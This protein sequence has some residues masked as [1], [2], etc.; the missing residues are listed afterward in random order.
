MWRCWYS[1]ACYLSSKPAFP[2]PYWP[3][4]YPPT[5]VIYTNTITRKRRISP[6]N[7]QQIYSQ[8]TTIAWIPKPSRKE[9]LSEQI[10]A[11]LLASSWPRLTRSTDFGKA[12]EK[13]HRGRTSQ[14][15]TKMHVGCMSCRI[16]GQVAATCC[17]S[18]SNGASKHAFQCP[19][20]KHIQQ[21][22]LMHPG[23][24]SWLLSD[25]A[26]SAW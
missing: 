20:R 17:T 6:S 15:G 26:L 3:S 7:H 8:T 21:A 9:A 4:Q 10:N 19:T 25:E 18:D 1:R 11:S 5:P 22:Q 14:R 23:T 24:P 12:L 13:L 2:V 16:G